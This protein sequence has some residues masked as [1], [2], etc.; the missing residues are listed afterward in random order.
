[1]ETTNLAVNGTLMRGFELNRNLLAAGAVFVRETITAPVYR[2]WSINDL[3]PAMLR[4][5]AAGASIE[6]EIWLLTPETLVKVLRQE[7]PGLTIGSVELSDG[8]IVLGVLAEPYLV[9]GKKEITRWGGWRG[10]LNDRH[11]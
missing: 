10:Y 2:L 6:V 5:E 7:P 11:G 3:Y 9:I 1:M 8:E 4:D